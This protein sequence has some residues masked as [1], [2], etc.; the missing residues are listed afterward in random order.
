MDALQLE[1]LPAVHLNER[2]CS[3][4]YLCCRR[5]LDPILFDLLDNS[6]RRKLVTVKINGREL[7]GYQYESGMDQRYIHYLLGILLSVVRFGGQGFAKTAKSV[8]VRRTAHQELARRVE[9][10]RFRIIPMDSI[11]SPTFQLS[12]LALMPVISTF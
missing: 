9:S 5:I 3:G 11:D 12:P 1:I 10:S 6:I 4:I 2:L 8:P 7:P